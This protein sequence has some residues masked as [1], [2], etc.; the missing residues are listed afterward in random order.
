MYFSSY[1]GEGKA[2]IDSGSPYISIYAS[3]EATFN[4]IW[5]VIDGSSTGDFNCNY[6]TRFCDNTDNLMESLTIINSF[7]DWNVTIMRDDILDDDYVKFFYDADRD[8]TT[9]TDYVLFLGQPYLQYA[10]VEL[11]Y[12]ND[13]MTFY[14]IGTSTSS[15]NW[16]TILI[17]FACVIAFAGLFFGVYY[18]KYGRIPPPSNNDVEEQVVSIVYIYS[19]Y[20]SLHFFYSL[21]YKF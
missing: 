8:Y 7:D 3:S 17:V 9:D 19:P 21:T 13:T 11:N 4:T 12:K 16:T 6:T 1:F 5:R 15:L 10:A 14:S 2:V 18:W 20:F